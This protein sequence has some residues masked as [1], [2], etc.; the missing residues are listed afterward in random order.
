VAGLLAARKPPRAFLGLGALAS[1]ALAL[2]RE[3]D[4][5]VAVALARTAPSAQLVEDMRREPDFAPACSLPQ[6][7]RRR[8]RTANVAA[9]AASN[10]ARMS[11]RIWSSRRFL[12]KLSG[13]RRGSDFVMGH[14]FERTHQG[15]MV[16][17]SAAMGD[18]GVEELV[19]RRRVWQGNAEHPR[20]G[21][22]EI[23]VL[24]GS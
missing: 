6:A 15:R 7:R 1:R 24:L 3:P 13:D 17:G 23:E 4:D 2:I 14:D 12:Q 11:R 5:D 9:T 19:G 20:A 8:C 18:A 16:M 22:R 10:I 21:E